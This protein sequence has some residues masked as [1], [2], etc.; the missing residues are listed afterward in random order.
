MDQPELLNAAIAVVDKII[1]SCT[2]NRDQ[3]KPIED[4]WALVQSEARNPQTNVS[5]PEPQP[6]ER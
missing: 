2:G 4:A 5:C 3:R 6:I 1:A